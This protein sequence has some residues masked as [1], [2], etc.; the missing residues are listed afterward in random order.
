MLKFLIF[1]LFAF[2]LVLPH[3]ARAES[4]IAQGG[5]TTIVLTA[6]PCT[7]KKVAKAHPGHADLD[8]HGTARVTYRGKQLE[9]CW[10]YLSEQ[11]VVEII[12]ETGDSG[13]VPASAFKPVDPV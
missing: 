9:A 3:G 1:A 6:E 2:V 12:D 7:S 5:Q 10:S 8:K 11:G 13:M 4:F